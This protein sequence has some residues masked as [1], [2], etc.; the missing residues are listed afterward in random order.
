MIIDLYGNTIVESDHIDHG[1]NAR[2]VARRVPHRL[3]RWI[4][5]RPLRGRR[6]GRHGPPVEPCD[7][8]DLRRAR[9]PTAAAGRR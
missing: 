8:L 2:T 6:P 5:R 4:G 7:T 3:E 9:L 1:D